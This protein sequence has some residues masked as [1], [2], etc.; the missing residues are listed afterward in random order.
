MEQNHS[1][2]SLCTVTGAG[3]LI[4]RDGPRLDL[5]E[6]GGEFI[7]LIDGL[8]P[9]QDENE[10]SFGITKDQVSRLVERGNTVRL[11]QFLKIVVPG[12][13]VARCVFRGLQRPLCYGDNLHGDS[14]KFVYSW[15]PMH[16]FDWPASR[17]FDGESSVTERPAPP[18]MVF[19]VVTTPNQMRGLFP[20]V[21]FWIENNWAW[22]E[23][24]RDLQFAPIDWQVRY[25]EKVRPK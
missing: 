1:G 3:Q 13:I 15:K 21:D 19:A 23:E 16:D 4:E 18:G 5:T 24:A 6:E 22:I 17:R 11:T 2:N 7:Y 25:K 14:E 10:V 8:S 20:S 12:L 9:D